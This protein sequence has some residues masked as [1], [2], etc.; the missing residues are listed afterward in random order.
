M[1][2]INNHQAFAPIY[3]E[4]V[5]LGSHSVRHLRH[6]NHSVRHLRHRN[7]FPTSV[8]RQGASYFER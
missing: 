2:E 1:A 4:H 3:V 7:Q 6:R 5:G 8:P